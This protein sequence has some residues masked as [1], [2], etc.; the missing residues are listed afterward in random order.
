MGKAAAIINCMC[1]A[2]CG[3]G[4]W[5]VIGHCWSSFLLVLLLLRPPLP[6]PLLLLWLSTRSHK[7]TALSGHFLATRQSV[8][9]TKVRTAPSTHPT[10]LLALSTLDAASSHLCCAAATISGRLRVRWA[11]RL[12]KTGAAVLQV[13]ASWMQQYVCC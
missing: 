7:H 13:P 3:E 12:V 2:G 4:L 8:E 11:G 1:L 9:R 10:Q 5:I 6:L